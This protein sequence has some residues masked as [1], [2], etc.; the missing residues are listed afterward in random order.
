MN[1]NWRPTIAPRAGA[2]SPVTAPST[3]TGTPSAPKATGAVL[4]MRTNTSAS[5]AGKPTRMSSDEVI[6]TGVPKPAMPSRSAPK[7]KPMTTRTTRRSFG[8]WLRTHARNAS[9]RFELDCDIVEEQRVDDDPHDRP[10]REHDAVGD[11]IEGERGRKAPD[12][13]RENQ[14]DHE[15]RQGRLPRR[16]AQDAEEHENGQDGE[17]CDDE[18]EQQA[19]GDRR[20][21]LMEHLAPSQTR[22]IQRRAARLSRRFR[23]M[24]RSRRCSISIR[25]R[26]AFPASP[27]SSLRRRRGQLR[28]SRSDSVH[29]P[30][31]DGRPSARLIG[32]PSHGWWNISSIA[33]QFSPSARLSKGAWHGSV[34]LHHCWVVG[35]AAIL[36]AS[37]AKSSPW[38]SQ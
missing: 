23:K 15:P 31:L 11:R 14:S 10:E 21:Q 16:P 3:V 37:A 29:R 35:S 13:D 24:R 12:R 22:D 20:E 19:V 9:N 5:R 38:Y 28:T 34:N 8:R 33:A 26:G 18:R 25:R 32:I 1:G 6:A 17:R 2:G 30:S 4:K 36:R 27:A 7:Q